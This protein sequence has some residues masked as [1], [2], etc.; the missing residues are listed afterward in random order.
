[1]VKLLKYGGSNQPWV[2]KAQPKNLGFQA[3]M[4]SPRADM[5]C[6]YIALHYFF[7]F[8]TFLLVYNSC[9]GGFVVTFPYMSTMY[10]NL[11]H[12]LHYSSPPPSK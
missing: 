8:L 7:F 4:R 5:S 3:T 2:R 11:V 9:T 10:P 12:P 1:M 6:G